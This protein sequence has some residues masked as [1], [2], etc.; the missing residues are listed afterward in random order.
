MAESE[1]ATKPGRTAVGLAVLGIVY[2]DIGTSP[3][4]ALRECF[5]G[6]SPLP[7]T[8][9]NILGILSLI[10]WAL[11]IVI[12]LKYMVFILRA[13]NH[14]EGGIFA[15]L[16]LLRPDKD[17]DSRRRRT[18]ILLGL[19]GAGLLYGG[20][21]LTPAISVLSAVEGL[22]V[23]APTLHNYV[24]PITVTILVMLFA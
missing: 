7:I 20:T 19:F 1:E 13:N 4:Y 2:G 9:A 22:E 17:Q 14:G 16:A 8:E 21:M 23:A 12:S 11:I 3:I 18:L 6:V 15:L 10:F 5:R 24:L